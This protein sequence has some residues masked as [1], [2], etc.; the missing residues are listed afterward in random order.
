MQDYLLFI[1]TET[2]GLP[3]K[4][5]QPYCNND[6]WPYALQVS[7]IVYTKDG[8]EVKREDHYIKDNDFTI[9][10][11]AF[12]VHG[13]TPQFLLQNGEWRKDVMTKLADDL[14]HF[15]PLVVGH[16]IELD[17]NIAGVEFYRTGIP[18]PLDNLKTFCTMLATTKWVQNP[19]AKYLRLNQLYEVLFGKTLDRQHNAI[20]D[21]EATAE[22]FFEMVKRGDI[23]NDSVEHQEVYLQKIRSEKKYLL[24]AAIVLILIIILAVWIHGSTS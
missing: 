20:E 4:W 13:L 14:I 16:F 18:N 3:I 17:L 22:C 12:K 23:N 2:S 8:R 10:E 21:A 7:W 15:E 11:K 1:D 19:Q 24:P 5:D 9:S 6:N